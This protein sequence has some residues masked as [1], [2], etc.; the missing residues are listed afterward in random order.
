MQAKLEREGS[1]FLKGRPTVGPRG[2]IYHRWERLGRRKDIP[3]IGLQEK[4]I[5]LLVVQS[6]L[7][8]PSTSSSLGHMWW[9]MEVNGW[10]VKGGRVRSCPRAEQG[11]GD[12][13]PPPPFPNPGREQRLILQFTM[14]P[15]L[16]LVN[17]TPRFVETLD[18]RIWM[19]R[20]PT[21]SADCQKFL[22]HCCFLP[23]CL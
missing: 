21:K 17:D 9:C 13:A 2:T 4:T 6:V 15:P 14:P 8:F 1:T 22:S 5:S 18:N 3:H 16:R 10:A 23:S 12:G 11:E 19:C 20:V 7:S